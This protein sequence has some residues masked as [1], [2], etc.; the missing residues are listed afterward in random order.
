MSDNPNQSG[1]RRPPNTLAE[2]GA[3]AIPSSILRTLDNVSPENTQ[4][5]QRLTS[6]IG[7]IEQ[8]PLYQLGQSNPMLLTHPDAAKQ[9]RTMESRLTSYK[10][11]QEIME[12]GAAMR[13][14]RMVGT[15]VNQSFSSSAI[16]GQVG[17]RLESTA[18]QQE[19]IRIAARVDP[20]SLHR[21]IGRSESRMQRY[22]AEASNL[23]TVNR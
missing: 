23:E 5:Y 11:Q 3:S 12:E 22:G 20:D 2:L 21:R 14:N 10:R 6:Q 13:A 4:R 1:N 8:N 7:G 18:A 17:S 15:G 19:S 9:Y 16:N